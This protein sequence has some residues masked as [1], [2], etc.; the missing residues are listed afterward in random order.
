MVPCPSG[1]YSNKGRLG[2]IA[3]RRQREERACIYRNQGDGSDGGLHLS[4]GPKLSNYRQREAEGFAPRRDLER[5]QIALLCS[6]C[7]PV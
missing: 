5:E 4:N 7:A 1:I 2:R 6:F 3:K